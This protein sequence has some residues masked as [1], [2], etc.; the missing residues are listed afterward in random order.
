[1]RHQVRRV[2]ALAVFALAVSSTML[3]QAGLA[4]PMEAAF[5][6]AN[7]LILLQVYRPGPQDISVLSPDGSEL[8]RLATGINLAPTTASWSPDG[9]KIAYGLQLLSDA[10]SADIYVMNAD[11]SGKT[12][13]TDL[14]AYCFDPSWSPDGSQI[15]FTGPHG[16]LFVMNADGSGLTQITTEGNYSGADWSSTGK[17]AFTREDDHIYSM[18]PDGTGLTQITTG[19]HGWFPSWSPDGSKILFSGGQGRI[20]VVNVGGTGLTRIPLL[21]KGRLP[22]WSPDGTMFAFSHTNTDGPHMRSSIWVANLDGS[23]ATKILGG[24]WAWTESWQAT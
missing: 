22:V 6:G 17:I 4:P 7:G 16:K 11:G 10:D 1:M 20:F 24:G 12:Q 14:H 13:L 5:P 19:Y 3:A 15:V 23:G 18:N 8:T 2:F 9:T 21:L